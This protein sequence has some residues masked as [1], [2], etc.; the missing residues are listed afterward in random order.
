MHMHMHLVIVGG[1]LCQV[2]KEDAIY[3]LA[4]RS[5]SKMVHPGQLFA[6]ARTR[7]PAVLEVVVL[8]ERLDNV[9]AVVT[10]DGAF[11]LGAEQLGHT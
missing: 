3:L 11:T 2:Q 1:V 8:R 10:L 6:P 9:V 5:H 4:M 7:V